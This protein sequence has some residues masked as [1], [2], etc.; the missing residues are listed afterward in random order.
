MSMKKTI[1]RLGAV[2]ECGEVR[3]GTMSALQVVRECSDL[4]DKARTRT[5]HSHCVLTLAEKM[6]LYV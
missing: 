2:V 5:D 1:G 6:L 3:G 4:E